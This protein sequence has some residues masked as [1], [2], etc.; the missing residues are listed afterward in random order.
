V[1]CINAVGQ[2]DHSGGITLVS[3]LCASARENQP[4]IPDPYAGVPEPS[5]EGPCENWNA[6]TAG[7]PHATRNIIATHFHFSGFLS[8]RFCGKDVAIQQRINFTPGIYI[9]DGVDMT[10][11]A[12]AIVNGSDV[13]FYLANGATLR[14]NGSSELHLSAMTMGDLA[15]ILFYVSRAS[16]GLSHQLNGD[17]NS[18][19]EGVIYI[20]NGELKYNGGAGLAGACTQVIANTIS[21]SGSSDFQSDCTDYPFK[22]IVAGA[23]VQLVD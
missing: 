20:P 19:F 4:P 16:A 8:K 21:F 22:E 13:M 17:S 7:S 23:L 6:L 18:S 15:P 12:N 11:N 9:L 3:P 2:V 14:I 5:I 10:V 1:E